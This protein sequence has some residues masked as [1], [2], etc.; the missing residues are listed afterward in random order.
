MHLNLKQ[1]R[2]HSTAGKYW[3]GAYNN[4]SFWGAALLNLNENISKLNAA[5]IIL[6]KIN[7]C[8][9]L[10][11]VNTRTLSVDFIHYFRF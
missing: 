7:I 4:N 9:I 8:F 3:K 10:K 11:Y 6:L 1:G 5:S 2:L